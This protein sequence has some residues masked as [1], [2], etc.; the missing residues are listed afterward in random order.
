MTART[1]YAELGIQLAERA[2][3]NASVRCFAQ[4][5]NHNRGDRNPSCSVSL[6]TGAWNCHGCGA[7]G[8]AYDAAL[9]VGHTRRAAM[10][11]LKQH[12][13]ICDRDVHRTDIPC[14]KPRPPRQRL[15]G[16]GDND[17]KSWAVRLESDRRLLRQLAIARAWASRVIRDLEIGFDGA[18]ITIPIRN[19]RG[20]L[21]GL[22]RYDPF[23][24]RKPKMV[25]VP[26]TR[27]GL[28]PHPARVT[29][30]RVILVE[31][32]P[33]MLAARSLG[34]A[35]IAVPGTHAWQ[36]EWAQ[37]LRGRHVTV[38]MDCDSSGR[39]AAKAIE[40]S[41][42]D[43]DADAKVDTVDLWPGRS[44]GYDLTDR[45]IEQRLARP[46]LLNTCSEVIRG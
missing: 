29:S 37:L 36:P 18:R 26:G 31:G 23:G 35:A 5:D 40:A 14:A 7:H 46:R 44:D 45:I 34:F 22:L 25:C 41:L 3:A 19:G 2:T 6:T 9:A 21:R 15:L 11:L 42:R 8:G 33:D 27:L 43:A 13:L 39:Q 30:K 17:V 32:P 28:V 16:A 1:F 4:P 24:R 20:Q 12:G 10:Q 38:V